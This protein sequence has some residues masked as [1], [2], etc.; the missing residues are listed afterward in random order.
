MP[1]RHR[2][3]SQQMWRAGNEKVCCMPQCWLKLCSGRQPTQHLV[4][5]T[6]SQQKK[7]KNTSYSLFIFFTSFYKFNHAVFDVTPHEHRAV[8]RAERG[9]ICQIV[10]YEFMALSILPL[11][12]E[13]YTK[14]ITPVSVTS[15]SVHL[16]HVCCAPTHSLF[17]WLEGK[18]AS[19]PSDGEWAFVL[20]PWHL[21][22]HLCQ[23]NCDC[24]VVDIFAFWHH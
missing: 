2:D 15:P 24:D 1:I 16:Q 23:S 20:G 4:S 11:S 18:R 19:P 14:F 6:E 9:K 12:R 13:H 21:T 17:L 8:K 7:K 5:L 3:I 22:S 10:S